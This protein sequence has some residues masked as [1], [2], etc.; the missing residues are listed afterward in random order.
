MLVFTFDMT[1]T[2]QLE[3]EMGLIGKQELIHYVSV[4]HSL[5]K[6][7]YQTITGEP[8]PESGDENAKE[9]TTQ[10]N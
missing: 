9:D 2:F 8:Y 4:D 10:S 6:A 5:T 1:P 7:G 3:Y